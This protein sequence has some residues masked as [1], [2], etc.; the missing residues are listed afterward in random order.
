VQCRP[1]KPQPLGGFFLGALPVIHFKLHEETAM[2]NDRLENSGQ[3]SNWQ[4]I[5]IRTET[6][7]ITNPLE[8]HVKYIMK[9]SKQYL[10]IEVFENDK[11]VE[12]NLLIRAVHEFILET[13]DASSRLRLV[14]NPNKDTISTHVLLNNEE[15]QVESAGGE[16][17]F[18]LNQELKKL[19]LPSNPR[20]HVLV[21]ELKRKGAFLNEIKLHTGFGPAVILAEG[22]NGAIGACAAAC[23]LCALG[24]FAG[25]VACSICIEM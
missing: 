24:V 18:L 11:L 3:L 22:S 9:A 23:F 14:I 4:I 19:Q 6:I 7:E 2:T 10:R 15:F 17:A 20:L 12:E 5:P 1:L 21:E 16:H 25:C 8:P 13:S